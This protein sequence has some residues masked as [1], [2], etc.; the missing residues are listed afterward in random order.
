M[1]KAT[2]GAILRESIRKV[3]FGGV[4][5]FVVIVLFVGA[6]LWGKKSGFTPSVYMGTFQWLVIFSVVIFL[7]RDILKAVVKSFKREFVKSS[8]TNIVAVPVVVAVVKNLV[9]SFTRHIPKLLGGEI[10]GIGSNQAV[11]T[12]NTYTLEFVL[13]Y[14]ISPAVFEEILFRY[15]PYVGLAFILN[16]IVKLK[17]ALKMQRM[18]IEVLLY[19]VEKFRD[20][21]FKHRKT[22]A[23]V[24]WVVLTA[25]L[26]SLAH[27]PNITNFYVYFVGGVIY[28]CL[29]IYY[30]LAS[31]MIAH[32]M[33]N[34]TSP[35]IWDFVK[36]I[37]NIFI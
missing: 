27:G 15:L 34:Y 35:V 17:N 19:P 26:F 28:G 24:I 7:N 36:G 2:M 29:Y 1:S 6:T 18:S 31:S 9:I 14:C 13:F 22:Y 4:Y 32:M 5:Y 3:L 25:T 21:L 16:L 11:I 10:I 30:G 20:D 23:V 8:S 37:V 33:G 12:V